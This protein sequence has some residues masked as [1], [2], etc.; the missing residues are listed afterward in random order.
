MELIIR[1]ASLP[2]TAEACAILCRNFKVLDCAW[3]TRYVSEQVAQ[4]E[5]NFHE[6]WVFGRLR[7]CDGHELSGQP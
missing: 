7:D 5:W 2:H 4:A 3:L 6:R 1:E